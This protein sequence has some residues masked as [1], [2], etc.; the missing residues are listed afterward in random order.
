MAKLICVTRDKTSPCGK[1]GIL[2]SVHPADRYL[3]LDMLKDA[4]LF[5]GDYAVYYDPCPQD[6]GSFDVSNISLVIMAVTEKYLVWQNSGFLSEA[7]PAVANNIPVLPLM[8]ENGIVNLFNT[9]CGKLQYVDCTDSCQVAE[10]CRRHLAQ[11]FTKEADNEVGDGKRRVFISY[12]KRDIAQLK[13]LSQ[14]IMRHPQASRLCLWYDTGLLPGENYSDAILD[15]LCGCDLYVLL[16][17]P[18]LLE[19]GNYVYRVEYPMAIQKGK[20]IVAV[21]MQK[22]DRTKLLQM[23]PALP[24]CITEKQI[25]ALFARIL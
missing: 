5:S 23:Y 20:P 16:V 17:T 8:M 15:A 2:L 21:E 12:R 4:V 9:R 18:S 24:K 14:A 3:Y 10:K 6:G 13:R 19:E 7:I 25:D 11:V 1:P 22:T